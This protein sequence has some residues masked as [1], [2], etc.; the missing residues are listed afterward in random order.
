MLAILV[1]APRPDYLREEIRSA[2]HAAM[3]YSIGESGSLRIN[4]PDTGLLYT[5]EYALGFKTFFLQRSLAYKGVSPRP[6]GGVLQSCRQLGLRSIEGVPNEALAA[7]VKNPTKLQ[8]IV[9]ELDTWRA[10]LTRDIVVFADGKVLARLT[11][12]QAASYVPLDLLNPPE[13]RWRGGY[14][15]KPISRFSALDLRINGL[16]G[17]G[18]SCRLDLS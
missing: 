6:P 15:G 12:L 2:E 16:L 11:P 7:L 14:M 4:L 13:T 10:S 8:A 5:P 3:L 1:V 9:V 17:L 18:A